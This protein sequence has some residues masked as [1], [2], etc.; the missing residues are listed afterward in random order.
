MKKVTFQHVI[1]CRGEKDKI[2]WSTREL[3]YTKQATRIASWTTSVA[4]FIP[5]TNFD[6]GLNSFKNVTLLN[7]VNQVK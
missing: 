1:I 2:R 3:L 6:K 5:A 4:I 7:S